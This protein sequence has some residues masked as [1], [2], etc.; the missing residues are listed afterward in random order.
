MDDQ[1]R[2]TQTL[3]KSN[4]ARKSLNNLGIEKAIEKAGK[5]MNIT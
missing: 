5:S 2:S 1:H 3:W 4:M